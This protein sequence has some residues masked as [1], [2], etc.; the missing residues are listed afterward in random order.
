MKTDFLKGLGLTEEQIT[1]IMAEN[2]KDIG[3]EQTK[4]QQNIDKLTTELENSKLE[5]KSKDELISNANSEI[6]KFKGLD[7]EGI[8]AQ[9]EEWKTKYSEFEIKSKADKEAY[10]KQLADQARD[11]KLNEAVNTLKF[12]NE[13]TKK[14][15]ISE[16]KEKNLPFEG[17]KFLGFDDYVKQVGEQ[18]P[19]IFVT[20]AP[21]DETP[22]PQFTTPSTNQTPLKKGMSLTEAMKKANAGE[23]VDFSQIDTGIQQ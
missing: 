6:E 11:F 21:I 17:D 7:V 23:K 18:N 4:A 1:S 3:K 14:A 2:G 5:L 10:E 15:F 13:L 16:L 22:V 8:K 20:E 19:G 9:A 12:P